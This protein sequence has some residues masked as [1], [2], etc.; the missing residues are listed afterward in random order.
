MSV[1]LHGQKHVRRQKLHFCE[2]MHIYH[3]NRLKRYS[4]HKLYKNDR[5]FYSLIA[6]IIIVQVASLIL[7][8]IEV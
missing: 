3:P 2:N 1:L 8:I 7:L 5:L 6:F 4:V